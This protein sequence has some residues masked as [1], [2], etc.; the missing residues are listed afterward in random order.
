MLHTSICMLVHTCNPAFEPLESY[1][2]NFAMWKRRK[3]GV[4]E[5]ENLSIRNIKIILYRAV[6]DN[7]DSGFHS[8]LPD[9]LN[10]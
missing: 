9:W 6:D 8:S 4:R 7:L 5:T 3:K 10:S 1:T 2:Y